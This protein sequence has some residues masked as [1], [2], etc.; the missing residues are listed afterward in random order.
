MNISGFELP[1]S[2]NLNGK[3]LYLNGASMRNKFFINIYVI[4]LYSEKPILTEEEAIYSNIERSLRMLIATP[5]ATPKTVSENIEEGI[6]YSLGKNYISLKPTVDR[7]RKVVDEA[8]I[9]YKDYMD[10]YFTSSGVLQMYK[11][12]V[13]LSSDED[14]KIFA[15]SLF[16]MYMGKNPKDSKIKRALLKGF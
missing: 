10:N 15:E 14:A 11:N 4:A 3:T 13:L 5:L 9:G 16:N 12:D 7:I 6:K 2:I 8:K 1:E